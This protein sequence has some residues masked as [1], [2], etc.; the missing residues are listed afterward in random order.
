[1][2]TLRGAAAQAGPDDGTVAAPWTSG[3]STVVPDQADID[4][5]ARLL[6]AGALVAF[7]TETVYGLGADAEN[8]SAVARIYAAKGRPSQH[9]LI[10]HLAPEADIG[11]WSNDVGGDARA[12]IDAFWPGPLTLILPRA[13]HVPDAAAG[14]QHS[15][16]LRCPSHPVAQS[17]LRSFKRGRGGV[18][19]PSANRFGQVSPT[20]ARHVR[21]EFGD[22]PLLSCVLDGGQSAVG[23]EST[24]ID[25]T[26]GRPVLLRPGHVSA[27]DIAAVLGVE[28]ALPDADAPRASG[29]LASH[30]APHTP[31]V[32]V[33]AAAIAECLS[34]LARAGRRAALAHHSALSRFGFVDQDDAGEPDTPRSSSMNMIA[35]R[36]AMS[37][38]PAG[39]AHD[40]YAVLRRLDLQCADVIIVEML[41]QDPAWQAVTD[42]LARAAHGS[43]SVLA[44]LI[45]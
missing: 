45:G 28:P 29:T 23:I 2:I 18:A 16:G 25:L 7:P 3:S 24:I 36:A 1:M 37:D 40:F 43:T 34:Q 26:R 41:P 15:L 4:A 21:D 39:Y 30:Y 5:A 27:A 20:L 6:E 33:P 9:P 13:P 42:R 35:A 31:V 10:V 11:Y 38:Q 44:S 8:P 17:L 22:S 12:L 19:A 14:G 32:V